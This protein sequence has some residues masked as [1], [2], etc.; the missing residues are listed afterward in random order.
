M[1]F[2]DYNWKKELTITIQAKD[3]YNVFCTTCLGLQHPAAKRPSRD[4][5][6]RFF[7]KVYLILEAESLLSQSDI[8]HIQNTFY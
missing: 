8:S 3:L 5:A 2:K 7:N 1:N 4:S 6:I